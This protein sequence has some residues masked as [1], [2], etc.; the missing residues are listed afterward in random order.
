LTMSDYGPFLLAAI[1]TSAVL[2]LRKKIFESFWEKKYTKC[3]AKYKL[4]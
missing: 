4:H 3:R 1:K 2:N